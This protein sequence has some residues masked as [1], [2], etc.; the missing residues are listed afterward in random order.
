VKVIG[1]TAMMNCP[2][3]IHRD[4]ERS[5]ACSVKRIFEKKKGNNNKNYNT[6]THTYSETTPRN[7]GREGGGKKIVS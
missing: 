6:H 4:K 1:L 5:V 2:L 3:L 7:V